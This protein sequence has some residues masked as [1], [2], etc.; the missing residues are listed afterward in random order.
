MNREFKSSSAA[1]S[2]FAVAAVVSVAVLP[3]AHA[4]FKCDRAQLTRVDATACA[5]AAESIDSL[6]QYVSRTR[7][8]YG[9]LM[10]DYVP[11]EENVPKAQ[12]ARALQA[13]PQDSV[14]GLAPPAR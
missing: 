9:L 13:N 5:K 10:T 12:P 1:R 14:A 11:P 2:V 6:R 7:M 3:V 4:E 8:I